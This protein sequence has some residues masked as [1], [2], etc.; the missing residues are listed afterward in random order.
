MREEL[1]ECTVLL[2]TSD[3][4]KSS[5]YCYTLC[6]KACLV[7]FY[8]P[9]P[10]RFIQCPFSSCAAECWE[11]SFSSLFLLFP[12]CDILIPWILSL[13]LQPWQKLY[14]FN[15]FAMLPTLQD[16]FFWSTASMKGM[17]RTESITGLSVSLTTCSL[18]STCLCI[19]TCELTSTFSNCLISIHLLQD[20]CLH[21]QFN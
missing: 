16:S 15:N 4:Q 18:F 2:R 9:L 8:N 11:S 7:L 1:F 21:W 6:G 20:V 5:I 12:H 10:G 3:G 14:P 13:V 17:T 19:N